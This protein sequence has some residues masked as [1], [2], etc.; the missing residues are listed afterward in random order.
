MYEEINKEVDNLFADNKPAAIVEQV[1]MKKDTGAYVRGT[2]VGLIT[3]SKLCVVVNTANADGSEVPYAIL[4][5]DVDTTGEL[6]DVVTTSFKSGSFQGTNLVFGG[7]DTAATHKE[8][9]RDKN[10]YLK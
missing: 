9:L 5:D 3:A 6:V 1:T 7:T 2:V 10:I 4:T 8:S